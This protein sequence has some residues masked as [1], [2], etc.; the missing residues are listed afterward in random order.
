[1][2][3]LIWNRPDGSACTTVF[4]PNFDD[5]AAEKGLT[6][7]ELLA[8]TIAK[9]KASRSDLAMLTPIE[10][11]ELDVDNPE[12]F[13]REAW[14]HDGKIDLTRARISHIK[15]I[16]SAIMARITIL[17]DEKLRERLSG[18]IDR[19]DQLEVDLST[20][21]ALDLGIL[22]AQIAAAINPEVLAAIW[23]VE[24]PK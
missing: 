5:M 22:T 7:E 19:A 9:I 16:V 15:L 18:N 20:L 17:R 14:G 13:G 10:V 6:S 24:L 21:K 11:E 1:M 12:I 3:R 8:E 2:K 23:P 4:P